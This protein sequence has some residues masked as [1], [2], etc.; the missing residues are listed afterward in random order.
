M[1]SQFK[2]V[3]KTTAVVKPIQT[4]CGK[5]IGLLPYKHLNGQHTG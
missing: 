5:N 4:L 3:K 2:V 1:S